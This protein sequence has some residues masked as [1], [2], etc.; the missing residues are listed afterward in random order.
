MVGDNQVN[1]ST[2]EVITRSQHKTRENV[3]ARVTIGFGFTSDCLKK[4]REIFKPI[5]ER[6]NVK[7]K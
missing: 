7:P 3:R 6:S 2:L 5:T 1:Q 4:W